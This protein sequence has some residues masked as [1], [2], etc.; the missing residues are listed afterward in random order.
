VRIGKNAEERALDERPL[1]KAARYRQKQIPRYARDDSVGRGT[2][3]TH[4]FRV[5][6]GK[7]GAP[8]EDAWM[9][10]RTST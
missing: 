9:A 10:P 6:R 1:R 3:K 7:D 2:S 4:P 5:L 8:T